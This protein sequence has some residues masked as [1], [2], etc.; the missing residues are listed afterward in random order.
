MSKTIAPLLSFDAGG[1]VGKTVV[2]SK[3][4]GV[5]YARR[6]T[7]PANPRTV[8]QQSNRL[9]FAVLREMF[10]LLP[11][12]GRAPWTAF[13]TGRAFTDMNAFVGE[14]RRAINTQADMSDFIG[15]PGA[16]GGLPAG[17]FSADTGAAAGEI[18]VT[19]VAPEVPVDWTLTGYAVLAFVNAA[20]QDRFPGPFAY[21]AIASPTLDDTLSGLT[22]GEEYV[23]S[24]WTIWTKPDGKTAYGPSL[25]TTATA[26]A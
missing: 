14:N 17:G 21:A 9:A 13:A 5:K 3:W 25:V 7:I 18:D 20:P 12:G 24:G 22:A 2:Y 11:A 26:G 23:V 10:K 8:A 6:Y 4:R 15:S 19:F 1:Q 16:R